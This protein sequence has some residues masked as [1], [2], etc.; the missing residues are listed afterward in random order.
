MGNIIGPAELQTHRTLRGTRTQRTPFGPS[1]PSAVDLLLRSVDEASKDSIRFDR[2]PEKSSTTSPHR[3]TDRSLA[4]VRVGLVMKCNS[5]Y[6][7]SRQVRSGITFVD[8][9]L[10]TSVWETPWG[11][12]RRT[13]QDRTASSPMIGCTAVS[14]FTGLHGGQLSEGE[15]VVQLCSVNATIALLSTNQCSKSSEDSTTSTLFLRGANLQLQ[16]RKR[17]EVPRRALPTSYTRWSP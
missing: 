5:G 1:V 11:N 16:T 13:R 2:R 10:P 14:F 15:I 12:E 7:E 3:T 6:L 8:T 9:I 4:L 17:F